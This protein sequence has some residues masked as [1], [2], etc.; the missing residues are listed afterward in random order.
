MNTPKHVDQQ[1][2]RLAEIRTQW[3]MWSATADTSN[4]EVTFFLTLLEQKDQEIADLKR[5]LRR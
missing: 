3:M 4:W 1:A 2:Q 5:A